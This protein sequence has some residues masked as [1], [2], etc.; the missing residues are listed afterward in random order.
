MQVDRTKI[1][2]AIFLTVILFFAPIVLA[3]SITVTASVDRTTLVVNEQLILTIEI[4]GSD[5]NKVKAPAVPDLGENL[6]YLG[7]GGTSQSIQII[8]NKMSVTKTYTFYFM[9]AKAG[10]VKIPP[11]EVQYKGKTFASS[12][13]TI[14]ITKA[15]AQAQQKQTSP[16]SSVTV[17][18]GDNSELFLRAIVNKKRVYQN[19][20]VIV[21]YRIYTRVP[22][23]SYGIS[24]LPETAGFWAE[25][26]MSGQQP[27][28]RDQIINGIRYTLADI[29]K[30]A[31]FP[32]S[33]GKKT[34]GALGIECDVR[35][36]RQ[37]RNRDVFDS[38]FDDPFFARTVRKSVFSKPVQIEVLPLPKEG[39]PADFSGA[40]GQFNLK[41]NISNTK[42]KTN[43]A[44]SLKV[45]VSG[46]GNIKLLPEPK[47][48]IPPD[49]EKYEPKITQNISRQSNGISGSKTFE[50]V[51]IPRYAGK[52]RIKPVTFSY[53]DP[54]LKKYKTL[55]SPEFVINVAQGEAPV[56]S[57]GSGF[58]KREVQLIGKD[59]RFIK[60]AT[61]EFQPIGKRI[62]S[63]FAF[64]ALT[65][66]PLLLLT[67]AFGYKKHQEQLAENQA[68]ARSRR[69][70][71]V[72]LK[73]LSKAKGL[74][75][76]KSQ[77]DFYAEVSRALLGFAADKLDLSEAGIISTELEELL[78]ARNLD[79][80][81]IKE[82]LQLLQECDYQRFAPATVSGQEMTEFYKAAKQAI[83][84]LEKAI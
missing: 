59:I 41:A 53:F 56:A 22:V 37:R 15:T 24:K 29:K 38:F 64:I 48:A 13:I 19:E 68:L 55:T 26:L 54:I 16:R 11:I 32:T 82:Y 20:P 52:Q 78:K 35:V 47:I 58:S 65:V 84:K 62:Y 23:T 9:A 12:P 61:P 6:R 31:L 18:K 76:E 49:F 8:N 50:Y 21:T 60:L 74:L 27:T 42:V 72:A 1:W 40:V 70:N 44:I 79:E 34:I 3:Q 63:S 77:K 66:L 75:D 5:A 51:L 73:R 30:T 69:A 67:G 7:S 10:T 2:G 39:K 57:V 4:S 17:P 46:T 43:E 71:R 36:R 14:T 81:L 33:P 25:D 28:T 80:Q 83:I 45:T